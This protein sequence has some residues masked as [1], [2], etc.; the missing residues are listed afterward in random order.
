MPVTFRPAQERC[1]LCEH[2]HADIQPFTI[3][4]DP[5]QRERACPDCRKAYGKAWDQYHKKGAAHG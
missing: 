2:R 3:P 5:P 4:S 1:S